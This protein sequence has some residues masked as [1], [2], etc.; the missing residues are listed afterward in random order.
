M[1]VLSSCDAFC[2]FTLQPPRFTKV[3]YAY[4]DRDSYIR[5]YIYIYIL[6]PPA[7][8][9]IFPPPPPPG[10]A[11]AAPGSVSPASSRRSADPAVPVDL[12]QDGVHRF[13][14]GNLW[15]GFFRL[16]FGGNPWI[17][18]K[19]WWF[20]CGWSRGLKSCRCL[21]G[22]SIWR[23]RFWNAPSVHSWDM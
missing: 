7:P 16:A 3:I 18:F 5:V 19:G 14:R 2:N 17:G 22:W 15:L 4:F 8:L 21:S 20:V 11:V 10:A 23:H 12:R 9:P 6:R 1:G 13:R